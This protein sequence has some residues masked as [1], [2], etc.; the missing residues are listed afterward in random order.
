[1]ENIEFKN[2]TLYYMLV[3]LNIFIFAVSNYLFIY[4]I[5]VLPMFENNSCEDSRKFLGK[6]SNSMQDSRK[7]SSY[8]A[9]TSRNNEK[10]N[11]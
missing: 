7:T 9:S 2:Y 3:S 8:N 4:L 1:M 5:R 6:V 10:I 11:W